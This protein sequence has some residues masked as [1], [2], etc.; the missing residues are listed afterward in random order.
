[1]RGNSA[2][3]CQSIVSARPFF[4]DR[5]GLIDVAVCMLGS[6]RR[7]KIQPFSPI[8][9]HNGPSRTDQFYAVKG[10]PNDLIVQSVVSGEEARLILGHKIPHTNARCFLI[11]Y[12]SFP[13]ESGTGFVDRRGN[14]YVLKGSSNDA[15][16]VNAL[17]KGDGVIREARDGYSL[18]VGPF[19]LNGFGN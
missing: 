10:K 18:I 16:Y 1:L 14:L 8:Y 13:G 11:D 7:L 3:T 17:L 19:D 6:D 12:K 9:G 4:K 15:G 5:P 2:N